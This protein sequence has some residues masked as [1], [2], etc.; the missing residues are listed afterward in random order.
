MNILLLSSLPMRLLRHCLKEKYRRQGQLV[1]CSPDGFTIRKCI[2]LFEKAL[3]TIYRSS[4]IFRRDKQISPKQILV[5]KMQ[6]GFYAGFRVQR[7]SREDSGSPEYSIKNIKAL[8]LGY[9]VH[10]H[11]ADSL[12]EAYLICQCPGCYECEN[13]RRAS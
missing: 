7:I 12:G 9:L 6:S 3:L 11:W 5:V 10:G 1:K 13:I 8:V 2:F 4:V